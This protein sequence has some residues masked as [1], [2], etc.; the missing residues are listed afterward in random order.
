[1]MESVAAGAEELSASV[2]EVAGAGRSVAELLKDVERL[3]RGAMHQLMDVADFVD[4]QLQ[5]LIAIY[6]STCGNVPS[7]RI[8][9]EILQARSLIAELK[10]LTPGRSSPRR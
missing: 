3:E 7:L 1:M 6:Q 9:R 2:R 5:Q 8:E 10:T 4:G